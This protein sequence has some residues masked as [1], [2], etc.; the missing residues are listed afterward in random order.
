MAYT[1]ADV[2]KAVELT[3]RCVITEPRADLDAHLAELGEFF[4][5]FTDAEQWEISKKACQAII[6]RHTL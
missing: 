2:E 1:D 3:D 4:A 6:G 5:Q